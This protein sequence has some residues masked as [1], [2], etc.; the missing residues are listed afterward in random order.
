[1]T[2]ADLDFHPL[3][4]AEVRSTAQW[5]ARRSRR[6]AARFL[7]ELSRTIDLIIAQPDAWSAH[8]HGTRMIRVSRFPYL[9]IYELLPA[10]LQVIAVMHARRRPGYWRRRLS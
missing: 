9:V 10:W 3:A 5:Y 8:L 1:M 2:P 7:T 6:A 4:A